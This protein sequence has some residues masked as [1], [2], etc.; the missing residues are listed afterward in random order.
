M[1]CVVAGQSCG[2]GRIAGLTG[3]N[4][5]AGFDTVGFA[6]EPGAPAP[7]PATDRASASSA[8]NMLLDSD[9]AE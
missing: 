3:T 2:R 6:A 9:T 1:R 4:D 7:T 5:A 8:P